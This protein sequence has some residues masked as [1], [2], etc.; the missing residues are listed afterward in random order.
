MDLLIFDA[1]SII[2][3]LGK[4]FLAAVVICALAALATAGSRR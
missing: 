2:L 4:A 1:S 3:L